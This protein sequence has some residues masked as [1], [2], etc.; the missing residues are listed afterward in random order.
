[1]LADFAKTALEFLKLAPRYLIAVALIAGA[2]L[3]LPDAW[4]QRIGINA[5]AE[6]HRQ[7]LGLTFLVSATL[8]G[9]SAIGACWVW[10]L[11]RIFERR[12]RRHIVKKLSS[13]NED[14]KQILRYYFAK[15]TRANMLK[16]ND[17]V[18]QGLVANRIIYRSASTGSL[19]EGFAHNIT[20][21]A[22][23]YI[24]ANPQVLQGTTNTY[25]TDKRDWGW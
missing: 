15:E 21:V 20:D 12:V 17:G 9:V 5:F 13:L 25:R 11:E 6:T 7:W 16:I 8:W 14:E 19:V 10:I 24:Q 3:F 4:L 22:W 2:L 1:M 18:V 23:D